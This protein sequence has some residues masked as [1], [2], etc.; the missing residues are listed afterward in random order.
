MGGLNLVEKI[1]DWVKVQNVLISAWDKSGLDELVPALL[2]ANPEIMIYSTGGTFRKIKEILG[3]KAEKHLTP[4]GKYT[5]QPEMQGGLVKTLDFKIYLG[6][7]SETYNEVHQQDLKDR[8][9]IPIDMV[10]CNLYP[11]RKVIA[12]EGATP[13]D[14]RA[15]IDIG[16]PCMIRGAAKNF[17][18]VAVVVDPRNYEMVKQE[19]RENNG[20][21]SFETRTKLM[22]TAFEHTMGYDAAISDYWYNRSLDDL[23]KIYEIVGGKDE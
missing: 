17:L 3:D 13:E 12:Q 5:G 8:E 18:R 16:G 10:V 22:K 1:D 2:E 20:M 15:N 21:I 7:L 4:V 19:L 11:F 9:A 6:L 14:A 23:K